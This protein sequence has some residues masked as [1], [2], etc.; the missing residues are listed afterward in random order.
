MNE[1][2]RTIADGTK[3]LKA[4]PAV[5]SADAVMNQPEVPSS[6]TPDSNVMSDSSKASKSDGV[7]RRN[8]GAKASRAFMPHPSFSWPRRQ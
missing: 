7:R 2:P 4:S 1:K 5:V 3:R 6:A 8:S